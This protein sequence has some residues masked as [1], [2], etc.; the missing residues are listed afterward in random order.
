MD[1]SNND[2]ALVKAYEGY[3]A[4]YLT[5]YGRQPTITSAARTDAKQAELYARWQAGE[6]GIFMPAKPRGDGSIRHQYA[7]D[8]S[9]RDIDEELLGKHGLWRP[10][11]AKDP[12][13]VE[14][15][16][17]KNGRPTGK[18]ASMPTQTAQAPAQA[19]AQ[20]VFP[21]R[22]QIVQT[23]Q[24]D[25]AL[26]NIM[27]MLIQS[28]DASRAMGQAAGQGAIASQATAQQI[29]NRQSDF[30]TM[31]GINNPTEPG[32]LSNIMASHRQQ[33]MQ[34]EQ[35]QG[36]KSAFLQQ[37]QGVAGAIDLVYGEG[38]S[39]FAYDN[40]IADVNSS[41]A[42]SQAQMQ[43]YLANTSTVAALG[44]RT[45]AAISEEE[46]K[47]K[48]RELEAQAELNALTYG[49]K[50]QQAR[51]D[52]AGKEQQLLLREGQLAVA[53]Q[54]ALIAASG[55]GVAL[56]KEE[57]DSVFL[58]AGIDPVDVK[59]MLR[60]PNGKVLHSAVS[61]NLTALAPANDNP[62]VDNA[63]NAVVL[64][65]R[66]DSLQNPEL[67]KR[68]DNAFGSGGYAAP[69]MTLARDSILAIQSGTD[70]NA[71]GTP[72]ARALA[73]L[74]SQELLAT[75]GAFA[76]NEADTMLRAIDPRDTSNMYR[77]SWQGMVTAAP[78]SPA[79]AGV[80]GQQIIGDLGKM[81]L[82]EARTTYNDLSV[83]ERATQ[84]IQAGTTTID[85]A[86]DEVA[87]LFRAAANYNNKIRKY[88]SVGFLPQTDYRSTLTSRAPGKVAVTA[89]TGL[90]ALPLAIASK[91]RGSGVKFTNEAELQEGT[92]AKL[93]GSDLTDESVVRR[94]LLGQLMAGRTA[95][96]TD[97]NRD[98]N[99]G[100]SIKDG[101]EFEN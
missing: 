57:S 47:A 92:N 58:S 27:G 67:V 98:R 81:T 32:F 26:S 41:L 93:I 91:L 40:I 48:Q 55:K 11:G 31:A 45:I 69:A 2:P 3:A 8:I 36:E 21:T 101:A 20:A 66:K 64:H 88:E 46:A 70:R 23:G 72:Q 99:L 90:A 62:T 79:F 42:A 61:S 15:A 37:S 16:G 94:L 30:L 56:T 89:L 52:I 28:E 13:H 97:V 53:E 29:A 43:Q 14:L 5:K 50:G 1:L 19:P 76:R 63:A 39:T 68:L 87:G 38:T 82:T 49:I 83:L 18:G 4:D 60:T 17:N 24:F 25:D 84:Q 10:F 22:G 86:T 65:G 78:K 9:Q 54:R 73:G 77:A 96:M 51:L 85:E 6:K 74:S 35:V 71:A 33:M 59:G 75:Q 7:L 12:V 34:L 95:A 100:T 44:A 80:I